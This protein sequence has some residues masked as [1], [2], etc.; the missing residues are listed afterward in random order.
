M[1]WAADS[2]RRLHVG[3]THAMLWWNWA[4]FET[5]C[6]KAEFRLKSCTLTRNRQMQAYRRCSLCATILKAVQIVPFYSTPSSSFLNGCH[7]SGCDLNVPIFSSTHLAQT[8]NTPGWGAGT[9]RTEASNPLRMVYTLG[10]PCGC[11]VGLYLPYTF[12]I[13]LFLSL[14]FERRAGTF[15]CTAAHQASFCVTGSDSKISP[16]VSYKFSASTLHCLHWTYWR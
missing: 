6:V 13:W 12:N 7:L 9:T 11:S 8:A 15:I 5:C 1:D 4:V 14:A 2:P 10:R 3:H 16:G